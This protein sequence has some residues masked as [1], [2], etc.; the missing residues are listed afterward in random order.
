MDS[1]LFIG[2]III[3]IVEVIKYFVPRVGGAVT[4]LVAA[5]V[6]LVVA[7]VDTNIGI[8]DIT[9]AQGILTGLSAAGIVAVAAK[10]N[11]ST[12]PTTQG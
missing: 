9:V 4:I 3:A 1:V 11:S 12:S 7:L 2:T 5:L 8:E 6:G 10:V